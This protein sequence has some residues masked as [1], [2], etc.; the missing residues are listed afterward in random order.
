MSR[1]KHD[2]DALSWLDLPSEG[3]D[4][5]TSPMEVVGLE[6]EIILAPH[7]NLADSPLPPEAALVEEERLPSVVIPT[8]ARGRP[9][10]VLAFE[11][12][13]YQVRPGDRL[14]GLGE[15]KDDLPYTLMSVERLREPGYYRYARE[16]YIFPE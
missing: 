11:R 10:H 3:D 9:T 13:E 8:D 2:C 6:P 12:E 14:Y 1:R 15:P 7:T 4:P 5:T 16:H